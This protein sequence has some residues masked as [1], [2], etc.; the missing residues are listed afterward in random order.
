MIKALNEEKGIGLIEALVAQ[1]LLIIG[2]ISVW[3]IFVAGS[4]FNAES[5]DKTIAANVAQQK[6]EEIMNTRFRYIVEEH[7]PGIYTFNSEPQP[8]AYEDSP[9]WVR[10]SEDQW[11]TSLPEGK[12]EISYPGPDGVD[13]DP[14][15]VKVTVSW[16]SDV[17]PD[18]SLS[19]ETLVSMTPGRFR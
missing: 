17:Y 8:V 14:L 3:S 10:D 18:A 1:V 7:P 15:Q 19:L 11:I 12:Y 16:L 5:E 6:I 4:R 13:S 9:Y 2:A